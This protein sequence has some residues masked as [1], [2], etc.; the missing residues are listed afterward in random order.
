M[1]LQQDMLAASS[2]LQKTV[3]GLTDN[4]DRITGKV[5]S[6]SIDT[7]GVKVN[8]GGQVIS[9]KNISTIAENQST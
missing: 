8:M 1:Q 7:S 2:M 3:T 4:G 6:V 5:D 9:L